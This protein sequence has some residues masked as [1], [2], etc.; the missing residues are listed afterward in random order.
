MGRLHLVLRGQVWDEDETIRLGSRRRRRRLRIARIEPERRRRRK[1]PRR[2]R[3]GAMEIALRRRLRALSRARFLSPRRLR[4][5]R[6]RSPDRAHDRPSGRGDAAAARRPRPRREA[7][8]DGG[9]P[10]R[11]ATAVTAWAGHRNRRDALSGVGRRRG[12]GLRARSA[13]SPPFA[14]A[15]RRTSRRSS[16]RR[17]RRWRSS[18]RSLPAASPRRRRVPSPSPT[19]APSSAAHFAERP[20]GGRRQ[21]HDHRRRP[22]LARAAARRRP[23]HRRPGQDAGPRPVGLATCT[24]AT[25]TP[26][27]RSCRWA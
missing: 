22:G 11:R 26:G 7:G 15:T 12:Q 10:G 2:R 9:R 14:P 24:S 18:R 3:H 4:H 19:S 8:H 21:G 17:T 27:R 20:D 1:L 6:R 16:M 23:D 13:A 25:T 5:P